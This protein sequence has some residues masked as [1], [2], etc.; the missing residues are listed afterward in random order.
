MVSPDQPWSC[1][2]SEF[3]L[4]GQLSLKVQLGHIYMSDSGSQLSASCLSFL[5]A[6]QAGSHTYGRPSR[7]APEE[8]AA[9]WR[10]P[11]GCLFVVV[12]VGRGLG[13]PAPRDREYRPR[14]DL[15]VGMAIS[16]ALESGWGLPGAGDA[17]LGFGRLWVGGVAWGQ[18][19][20]QSQ[21]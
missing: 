4:E 12:S 16:G 20:N 8:E 19:G 15:W 13:S 2:C 7:G 1:S 18:E 3:L 5:D 21:G 17:A 9:Q 6:S 10:E 14:G 11:W